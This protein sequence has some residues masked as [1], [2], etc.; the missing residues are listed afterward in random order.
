[1]D[2]QIFDDLEENECKNGQG[3]PTLHNCFIVNYLEF[4]NGVTFY[5][6]L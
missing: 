4:T 1:M 5:K 6:V 2:L 3:R